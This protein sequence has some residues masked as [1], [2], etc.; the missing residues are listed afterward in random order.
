VTVTV[1]T[2]NNNSANRLQQVRFGTG[3]NSVIDTDSQSQAGNFSVNMPVGASDYSF[4]V[5]RTQSGA[6]TV[7]LTV[8]DS[9]GE[10]KTFVGGGATAF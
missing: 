9:C 10:W 7:P 1:S 3:T 5:R 2:A 8:V 4:T 6:V